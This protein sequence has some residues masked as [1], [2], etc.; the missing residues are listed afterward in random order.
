M[1]RCMAHIHYFQLQLI[2]ISDDDFDS[3]QKQQPKLGKISAPIFPNSNLKLGVDRKL[4]H[5]LIQFFLN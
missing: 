2:S 5:R 1:A 3:D 4:Q